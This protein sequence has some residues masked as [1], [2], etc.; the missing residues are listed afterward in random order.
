[1]GKFSFGKPDVSVLR[2]V[3]PNQYGIKVDYTIGV[4]DARHILI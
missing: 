1:M 2:K 4:L 3:I